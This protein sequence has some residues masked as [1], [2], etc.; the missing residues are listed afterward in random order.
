MPLAPRHTRI[1][2]RAPPPPPPER[3]IYRIIAPTHKPD[4]RGHFAGVKVE[5]HG[6]HATVL[7]TEKQARFYLDQGAL[8]PLVAA[9]A[10]P[11]AAAKKPAPHQ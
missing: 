6:A 2:K 3:R 10:K 9:A 4:L 8:E 7:L 5:R 1:A 11:A